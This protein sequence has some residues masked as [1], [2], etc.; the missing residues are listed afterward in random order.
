MGPAG[1]ASPSTQLKAAEAGAEDSATPPSMDA[2]SSKRTC[3]PHTGMLCTMWVLYHI[4][5]ISENNII[6][7]NIQNRVEEVKFVQTKNVTNNYEK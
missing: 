7:K 6:L 1:A 4:P 3:L 2:S 5:T